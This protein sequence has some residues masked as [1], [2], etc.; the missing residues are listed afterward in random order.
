[1]KIDLSGVTDKNEY[2]QFISELQQKIM[3]QMNDFLYNQSDY[4]SNRM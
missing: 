2:T 4:L 3:S 1:M